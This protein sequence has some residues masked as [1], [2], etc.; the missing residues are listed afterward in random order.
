LQQFPGQ[1][2]NLLQLSQQWWVAP[3][4]LVAA[5]RELGYPCTDF[6]QTYSL[7]QELERLQRWYIRP[8]SKFIQR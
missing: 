6:P 5:L 8:A 3:C 1:P 2:L 7:K 4:T